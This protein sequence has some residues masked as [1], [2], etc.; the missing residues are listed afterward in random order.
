MVA[1]SCWLINLITW[2]LWR[3]KRRVAAAASTSCVA[4]YCPSAAVAYAHA[5]ATSVRRSRCGARA[6]TIGAAAPRSSEAGRLD[7]ASAQMRTTS[8]RG[9]NSSTRRAASA[10]TASSISA[11]AV[12]LELGLG[13]ASSGTGAARS[14][15]AVLLLPLSSAVACAHARLASSRGLNSEA[16]C[17]AC[18]AI[19]SSSAG[20]ACPVEALGLGSEG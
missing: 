17:A 18:V 15:E 5:M 7:A 1:S 16:R 9:R 20:S 14:T 4:L 8:S 3:D 10:A 6:V 13:S 11:G 19:A 12:W 2:S